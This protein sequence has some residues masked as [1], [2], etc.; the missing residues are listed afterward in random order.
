MLLLHQ[1]I[2]HI[3]REN[4]LERIYKLIITTEYQIRDEKRQYGINREAVKLPALPP[5]KSDKFDYLTCEEM[6]LS[7]QRRALEH[8]K[9]TYSPLEKAFRKF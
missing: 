3:F 1:I 7:D 6:L 8:V 4:H 5:G 9:F 2:L